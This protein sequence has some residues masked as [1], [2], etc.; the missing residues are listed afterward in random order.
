MATRTAEH[1]TFTVE[2]FRRKITERPSLEKAWTSFTD[3]MLKVGS[4]KRGEIKKEAEEFVK[5]APR[6]E[7]E[8]FWLDSLPKKQ[9]RIK[10]EEG[11]GTTH[12]D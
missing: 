5:G 11:F 12:W 2:I 3:K 10:A 1:G 9:Q 7:L 8:K 6:E 4:K